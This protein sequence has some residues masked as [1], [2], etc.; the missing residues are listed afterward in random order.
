MIVAIFIQNLSWFQPEFGDLYLV[1]RG[2][3][4]IPNRTITRWPTGVRG[5]VG[6]YAVLSAFHLSRVAEFPSIIR[7]EPLPD[8]FLDALGGVEEPVTDS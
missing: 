6:C 3:K 1:A 5:N 2:V 7:A 4:C 8:P